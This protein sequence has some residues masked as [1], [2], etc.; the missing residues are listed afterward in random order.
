MHRTTC[1]DHW[2]RPVRSLSISVPIAACV[3]CRCQVAAYS[4]VIWERGSAELKGFG[5]GRKYQKILDAEKRTADRVA[6]M[7]RLAVKIGSCADP[8]KVSL[9]APSPPP[10]D[11]EPAAMNETCGMLEIEFVS[12]QRCY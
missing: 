7:Q 2:G 3:G 12:G 6:S 8:F 11:L 10:Q 4:S 1:L 5:F 9:P